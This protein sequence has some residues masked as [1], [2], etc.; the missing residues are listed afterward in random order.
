MYSLNSFDV[1]M[2]GKNAETA[3]KNWKLYSVV[4]SNFTFDYER[5]W[6]WVM[7]DREMP[8]DI[9]CSANV[10][11]C[12]AGNDLILKF[13]NRDLYNDRI[14]PLL[15]ADVIGVDLSVL[16]DDDEL[17]MK[18]YKC[19]CIGKCIRD[20]SNLAVSGVT[21]Q[22]SDSMDEDMFNARSRCLILSLDSSY[23]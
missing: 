9:R 3:R 13:K 16:D 11:M 17:R 10:L 7:D 5:E 4:A 6:S 19:Y 2:N 18:V 23:E 22:F 12:I 21:A 15:V 20:I 1:V 14:K 8:I